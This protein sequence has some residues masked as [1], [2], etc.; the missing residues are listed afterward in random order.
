[1]R[2]KSP[3]AARTENGSLRAGRLLALAVAAAY[4]ALPAHAQNLVGTVATPAA[5]L[6]EGV[7]AGGT[8]APGGEKV[9]Y[10]G[11]ATIEYPIA[12]PPGRASVQPNLSLRYNSQA[13]SAGGYWEYLPEG[14]SLPLLAIERDR[15]GNLVFMDGVT[16]KRLVS[17]NGS[18]SPVCGSA[19]SGEYR[20]MIDD[21]AFLRFIYDSTGNAWTA[22]R[23]DGVSLSFGH[24]T[25]HVVANGPSSGLPFVAERWA[26]E[27]EMDANGNAIDY[28]YT[29]GAPSVITYAAR[30]DSSGRLSVA[31]TRSVTFTYDTTVAGLSKIEVAV[32]TQGSWSIASTYLIGNS[33]DPWDPDRVNWFIQRDGDAP[34]KFEYEKD[35][36]V[37]V[38]TWSASA[39]LFLQGKQT[40]VADFNGDGRTDIVRE[41]RDDPLGPGEGFW[42]GLSDPDNQRFVVAQWARPKRPAVTTFAVAADFNGDGKADVAYGDNG[43]AVYVALGGATNFDLQNWSIAPIPAGAK[44]VVADLDG[45]GRADIA[46]TMAGWT[47][48]I[49]NI[50]DSGARAFIR[51]QWDLPPGEVAAVNLSDGKEV[52]IAGDFNGD[53]R[54]D[55]ARSRG[56]GTGASLYDSHADWQLLLSR[57]GG[58]FGVTHM[59]GPG[60]EDVGRT[61]FFVASDKYGVGVLLMERCGGVYRGCTIN[62]TQTCPPDTI[63]GCPLTCTID[64]SMYPYW[65]D[66]WG[67]CHVATVPGGDDLYRGCQ[68]MPGQVVWPA[69]AKDASSWGL[70]YLGTPSLT[71]YNDQT[72]ATLP[73]AITVEHPEGGSPILHDLVQGQ[74]TGPGSASVTCPSGAATVGGSGYFSGSAR[75]DEIIGCSGVTPLYLRVT[76]AAAGTN[77]K[78]GRSK[79]ARV[80]WPHGGVTSF[81]YKKATDYNGTP[82][83][84]SGPI[85]Q[86]GP[87]LRVVSQVTVD[88][89]LGHS[90]TTAYSYSGGYAEAGEF[91]GFRTMARVN[92][93]GTTDEL[94]F[95]QRD[96]ATAD[97]VLGSVDDGDY[98]GRLARLMRKDTSGTE[99]L[100]VDQVWGRGNLPKGQYPVFVRLMSA[101]RT[102]T[103]G[104]APITTTRS[105]DSYDETNGNLLAT[106]TSGDGVVPVTATYAYAQYANGDGRPLW[107]VRSE[108]VSGQK[109]RTATGT[110][111]STTY[112]Y[113]ADATQGYGTPKSITYWLEGALANPVE[114]FTNN[115]DGTVATISDPVQNTTTLTYDADH[116][117]VT[118]VSLPNTTAGGATIPHGGT[119]VF[120]EKFGL[121]YYI[122]DDSGNATMYEYDG[123]GR[124]TKITQFVG[125]PA[126]GA[127]TVADVVARTSNLPLSSISARRLVEYSAAGAVPGM[128][129]TSDLET[130][131]TGTAETYIARYRYYDGLGRLIE[132]LE[133]AGDGKYS[134]TR[135]TYDVMG[136]PVQRDGPFLAADASFGHPAPALHPSIQLTLAPGGR[137]Q[138]V[139]QVLGA[140]PGPGTQSTK[141]LNMTLTYVGHRVSISDPDVPTRNLRQET[142]D[143]LGR[144]VE[145][146]EFDDAGATKT[147]RYEYDGL[148]KVLAV[149]DPGGNQIISTYDTLG[150]RTSLK[151]PDAIRVGAVPPATGPTPEADMGVWAYTYYADGAIKTQTDPNQNVI[152]W[153]Y[154]PLGRVTRRRFSTGE[155][156]AV[157]AYDD[158]GV[159]NARGRL[160]S[161]TRGT[162]G[163]E[164]AV[165][166]KVNAYDALG[167]AVS[168]T[169]TI[170]NVAY[171]T[172]MSRDRGGRIETLTYPDAY[173]VRYSYYPGSDNLKAIVGV[174]DNITY[175]SFSLYD[176]HGRASV[177]ERA[178]GNTVSSYTYEPLS[179]QLQELT[180]HRAVPPGTSL[181]PTDLLFYQ[182]YR[183]NLGSD[184]VQVADYR[185]GAEYV[186]SYD[187][188]GRIR[189]A[190][191]SGG[192]PLLPVADLSMTPAPGRPHAL[193]AVTR[194]TTSWGFT[195][196]AAGNTKTGWDLANLNAPALRTVTY[197]AEN[198]PVAI[199][200]TTSG[201]TTN[202]NFVY[203][204]DGV[205][206]VKSNGGSVTIY[207]GPHY[208][209][210]GNSATKY[211]LGGGLRIAKV[212]N[213]YTYYLH[214]DGQGSTVAVT[215]PTGAAIWLGGYRHT[216]ELS[217]E[218]G[219]RVTN[220]LYTGQEFDPES[221]LYNY[222]ARYLD[223]TLHRFLTPDAAVPRLFDPQAL[224]RYAY[225]RNSAIN[226]IDPTGNN[227]GP[228]AGYVYSDTWGGLGWLPSIALP[229]FFWGFGFPSSSGPPVPTV[230]AAYSAPRVAAGAVSG[231]PLSQVG[232]A[233]WSV[234]WREAYGS[235]AA[236]G[237]GDV[238]SLGGTRW[239][240]GSNP[241]LDEI[242]V[243]YID[244]RNQLAMDRA[245]GLGLAAGGMV[246]VVRSAIAAGG[247]AEAVKVGEYT[248]T[249]TVAGKLAE[250]PYLN[251]PL[252]LREIMAAGKPIPDP[253]GV[254]G[255]LRWDVPGAFRGSAGTWELVV[256]PRSNTVL[257]WLLK[258]APKAAP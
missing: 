189:R 172:L 248:L 203:D 77:P 109:T 8:S 125:D 220:Y 98:K 67:T 102:E 223:P 21:G 204:A 120:E 112:D 131:Q 176:P 257:H 80:M 213:L 89:G 74:W 59:L 141:T 249:R 5:T 15:H 43:S 170:R 68:N 121:P 150:R 157:L 7:S 214:A 99:L 93:D 60:Y 180:S 54:A 4:A 23:K 65:V 166:T 123:V 69:C 129:K 254:A 73:V 95:H 16:A 154:D 52:F 206:V 38:Q 212:R 32:N 56:G 24:G 75:L 122:V 53:G 186:Y 167:F 209:V 201:T 107:R 219:S 29:N 132:S 50:A 207:V 239:T 155:A 136:R 183:Y 41:G 57:P 191:A 130:G 118:R 1:M 127:S 37:E 18:I 22:Y 162:Q 194:G 27:R 86:V 187:A 193:G 165:T 114:S 92:P 256:D 185:A 192:A 87:G 197:S 31:A 85:N 217:W 105:W 115:P 135:V 151:D 78:S 20:L 188:R 210:E 200:R 160:T 35:P 178:G 137:V 25:G 76:S 49:V 215:D 243:M 226:R 139:S 79:L 111:R 244:R 168:T 198:L 224:N 133:P 72:Q 163:A 13:R 173:Q 177:V 232:T 88:D 240:L 211:I 230:H 161:S 222:G 241:R 71:Y 44:V 255:A 144:L 146:D 96:T 9:T 143:A 33:S 34:T 104:G 128:V 101:T 218:W 138:G 171:T 51:Q 181:Q 61:N 236:P 103:V 94:T 30:Y 81:Q 179:G 235:V 149:T 55:I 205:R 221:G 117:Y 62:P 250:R 158:P 42:V 225:A 258:S 83:G 110:L 195:Y 3:M 196:D 175:A 39:A 26:V 253:G 199:S 46:Y 10:T 245:A 90:S 70:E 66:A 113:F 159:P 106:T 169:K 228:W 108:T 124:V 145:V 147:S 208:A 17:C 2:E 238:V 234:G 156:D 11:A 242:L 36:P 142:L 182:G 47:Y 63:G 6:G 28:S 19:S 14:W 164:P 252:T 40:F 246:N 116:I 140:R 231:W 119:F 237:L 97:P 45:D 84:A 233:G 100:R 12:L 227:D 216:G 251:S 174:S 82:G 247:A 91:R 184:V 58:G 202:T 126:A 148:G 229:S 152:T 48:W 134:V 190:V 153:E 64:H